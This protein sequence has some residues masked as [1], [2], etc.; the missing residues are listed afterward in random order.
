LR[1]RLG[2][3]DLA[4][5]LLKGGMGQVEKLRSKDTDS[6]APNLALKASWPS[7]AALARLILAASDISPE[8]ALGAIAEISDPEVRLLCQVKLANRQLGAPMGRAVVMM[9]STKSAW[10]EYR[11]KE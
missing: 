6:D 10:S 8:T 9:L 2:E 11:A 4:K 7:T 5:K 3:I 1:R